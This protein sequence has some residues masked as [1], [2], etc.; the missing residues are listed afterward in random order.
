MPTLQPTKSDMQIRSASTSNATFQLWHNWIVDNSVHWEVDTAFGTDGENGFILK[1]L[2]GD[3][4]SKYLFRRNGSNLEIMIDP[5]GTVTLVDGSDASIYALPLRFVFVCTG[6]DRNEWQFHEWDDHLAIYAVDRSS[7]ICDMPVC[8]QIGYIFSPALLSDPGDGLTGQGLL[9]GITNYSNTSNILASTSASSPSI[10]R[11]G[12][13][14]IS[15]D[16]AE[17]FMSVTASTNSSFSV[18]SGSNLISNRN[19]PGIAVTTI[20]SPH[21]NIGIYKYLFGYGIT[22]QTPGNVLVS[23]GVS[24]F[25]YIGYVHSSSFLWVVPIQ[26]NFDPSAPPTNT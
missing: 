12:N 9:G 26:D 16:W 5:A 25:Q 7:P 11:V 6:T 10:V 19:Q 1:H 15:S 13:N 4:T 18:S 2:A 14:G 21:R 8:L 17:I 3:T 22:A 20:K 23:G 24:K